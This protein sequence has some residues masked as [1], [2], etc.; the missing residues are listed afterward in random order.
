MTTM[1][2]E[3]WLE[4]PLVGRWALPNFPESV[5]VGR[6]IFRKAVWQQP[7]EGVVVQYRQDVERNS[8]HLK[9]YADGTFRVDHVDEDNPDHGRPVQHFFN[10]HPVGKAM[11]AHPVLTVW[12]TLALM[13][14]VAQ[15]LRS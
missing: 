14:A 3:Y 11:K 4:Q 9:V 10:D 7:Y 13:F 8:A 5:R 6:A 15:A 1:L 2:G 12:G